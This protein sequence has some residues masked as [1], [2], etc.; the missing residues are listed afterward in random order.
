MGKPI[1]IRD[2]AE[3]MIKAQGL[4]LRDLGNPVGDI[5]IIVTGLRPGEK[6]HEEILTEGPILPTPHPKV[7]RAQ[8]VGLSEIAIAS[9]LKAAR[10]AI[11]DCDQ[12]A[13]RAVIS[14]CLDGFPRSED[15]RADSLS[16]IRVG[17][18][19]VSA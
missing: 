8:P 14:A 1:K 2:L 13:A 5:E 15:H 12:V 19:L 10:A 9:V 6:L 18:D 11:E 4:T 3:R 7:L 17:A 16:F